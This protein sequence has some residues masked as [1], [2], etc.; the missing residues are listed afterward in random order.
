MVTAYV[1]VK[2]LTG[3]ADRLREEIASIDGVVDVQIV[4]GDV[5]LFAKLDVEGTEAV[6]RIAATRIYEIDGVDDTQTYIAMD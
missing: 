2:A 6:K 4:A 3:R 5:D 1:A